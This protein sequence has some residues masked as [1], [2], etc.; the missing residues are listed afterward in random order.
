MNSES[1]PKSKKWFH[2]PVSNDNVVS[3]FDLNI[4]NQEGRELHGEI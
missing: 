1:P 3:R 2:V 4:H